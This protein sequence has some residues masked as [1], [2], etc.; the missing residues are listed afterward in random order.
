MT[1]RARVLSLPS[2][3]ENST[4]DEAGHGSLDII[5]ERIV[6]KVVRQEIAALKRELGVREE[7]FWNIEQA[8]KIL[9]VSE[10]WLYRHYKLPFV[11]KLGPK[12]LRFSYQ[13]I[14]KW[15]ETR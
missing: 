3:S 4:A 8:A 6:R 2:S 10:D 14:L 15:M 11:R 12:M 9:K 7:T 13:G 5:L 1:E